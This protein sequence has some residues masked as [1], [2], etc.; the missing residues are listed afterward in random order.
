[1][2]KQNFFIY[3]LGLFVLVFIANE[4]NTYYHALEQEKLNHYEKNKNIL[5]NLSQA[6]KAN[7]NLLATTLSND[8]SVIEAYKNNDHVMLQDHVLPVW[9]KLKEK[10]LIY[11]IHFFKPPAIS[12]VNFSDFKSLGNDV[13]DVRKD[14]VWVTSSFKPSTHL[15]MCKTYAGVRATHPIISDDGTMLGGISMGKKV[16]WLPAAM[17]KQSGDTSFLIYTKSSASSLVGKYYSDFIKDKE[18]FNNLILAERTMTIGVD[19]VKKLD[20]SSAI[21]QISINEKEYIINNYPI[22]DFN[23]EIMGYISTAYSLDPFY[24]RAF[25][26]TVQNLMI[27]LVSAFLIYLIMTKR[28]KRLIQQSKFISHLT[29]KIQERDFKK[30]ESMM[31][32]KGL[33]YEGEILN[34][35]KDDVL[36][37]GHT[38]EHK[39]T[40]LENELLEQLYIDNT[41]GMLNRNALM[42]DLHSLQK[43]TIALVNIRNFKQINDVFGFEK[44]NITLINLSK[45]LTDLVSKENLTSYH[46]GSDEFAIIVSEKED[47]E[48][49]LLLQNIIETI[50]LQTIEISKDIQIDIN[51]YSGICTASENQL[52]KADMA[53]TEAKKRNKTFIVYSDKTNTKE[54]QENNMKMFAVIKNA[55]DKKEVYPY[56]QPILDAK[57]NKIIKYEALMRIK[58]NGRVLPPDRFLQIAQKTKYYQELSRIIIKQALDKFRSI[59]HMISIN[60]SAIDITNEKTMA[61]LFKELNSFDDCHR[62]VIELTE[63]EDLYGLEEV[64]D[65]ITF[66]K[67]KGVKIAIDD[68]GVG[69]SNFSYLTSLNPDFIKID[70]S[71]ID[72][73][74]QDEKAQKLVMS[75]VHF[76][77]ELDIKIV[78][79]FVHNK[80][81]MQ[82]CIDLGIDELQGYYLGEPKPEISI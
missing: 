16:D 81:V 73:I 30:I 60:L 29:K 75:I 47:E 24:Y 40:E 66:V 57:T 14:I 54:I 10:K 8:P 42:R 56:Y 82:K 32:K 64:V 5:N 45:Q 37:M 55:L 44:G 59:D 36:S 53:L 69:Y 67:S 26:R 58:D 70:G 52:V 15:M 50:N 19:D 38:I 28:V 48:S 31:S 74:D 71:L 43:A 17:T 68:F 9:K 39:Y 62:V 61:F 46:L 80:A 33:F 72:N 63:T 21:N 18:E 22:Y 13:S 79:E 41:T 65:F 76:S 6:H 2:I 1:M 12:F 34:S 35:I 4:I 11:E 78:A 27:F 23:N 49:T 77:K 7:V 3:I 25:E 51:L 20:F